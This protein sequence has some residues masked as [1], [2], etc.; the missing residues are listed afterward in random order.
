MNKDK[1]HK[2]YKMNEKM[3]LKQKKKHLKNIML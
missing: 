2:G 3:K 1:M